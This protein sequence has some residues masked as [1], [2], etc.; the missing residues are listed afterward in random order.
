MPEGRSAVFRLVDI[1]VVVAALLILAALTIPAIHRVRA[2]S[3]WM[4]CV[5]NIRT[6]AI[7]VHNYH[8]DH[9]RLPPGWIGPAKEKQDPGQAPHVGNL[10]LLLPYLGNFELHSQLW[11]HSDWQKDGPLAQSPWWT[12][13]KP[14]GIANLKL[15]QARIDR[16]L[17]PVDDAY[18][19][20]KGTIVGLHYRMMPEGMRH[21]TWLE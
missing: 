1:I 9:N 10:V 18:A 13:T 5:D 12:L 14:N 17:C 20:T 21:I 2:W 8:N 7:A 11:Y 4:Q 15:A 16:L 19:S 6:V 3:E